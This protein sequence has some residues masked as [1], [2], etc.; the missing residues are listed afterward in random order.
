MAKHLSFTPFPLLAHPHLQTVTAPLF[1]VL[2]KLPSMQKIVTLDCLDK[3][4][5]EITRPESWNE[6]QLTVVLVHGLCGSYKSHYMVRMAKRLKRLGIRVVRMNLRG[7]GS[8][9]GLAKQPFHA[10][11]SEDLLQCLRVL[12]EEYPASPHLLVGWSIGANLVL[13]LAGEMKDAFRKLISAIFAINPPVDILESSRRFA[14]SANRMYE[15]FFYKKMRKDVLYRQLVFEDLPKFHLPKKLKM[16]EFDQIYLAPSCGFKDA[17]DYYHRSSSMHVVSEIAIPCKILY[18]K[19]DPLISHTSLDHLHLPSHIEIFKTNY[20]GHVGYLSYFSDPRGFFWL[21]SLIEEWI[22]EY[23][24][25][26][27][28]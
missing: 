13:K 16:F 15:R 12:K 21:D 27:Y 1:G 25:R 24:N 6:R 28:P 2:L 23:M 22:L 7:C 9:K 8:G 11:R 17:N 3:I 20:G 10:G 18:A 14:L 26:G 4:S 19:D 5:L